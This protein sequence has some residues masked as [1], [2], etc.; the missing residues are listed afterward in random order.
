MHESKSWDLF[1]PQDDQ[2]NSLA[3][4]RPPPESVPR[5]WKPIEPLRSYVHQQQPASGPQASEP[6][7]DFEIFSGIEIYDL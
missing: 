2:A 5:G 7:Q 3:N 4:R 1:S 6:T